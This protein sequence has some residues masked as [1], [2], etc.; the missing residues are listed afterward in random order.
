M[1]YLLTIISSSLLNDRD[2]LSKSRQKLHANCFATEKSFQFYPAKRQSLANVILKPLSSKHVFPIVQTLQHRLINNA[3]I[4]M[5]LVIS[6]RAQFFFE[7]SFNTLFISPRVARVRVC[8]LPLLS[9][10][11]WTLQRTFQQFMLLPKNDVHLQV[12]RPLISCMSQKCKSLPWDISQCKHFHNLSVSE[13]PAFWN[14][15]RVDHHLQY[16]K[17]F[18]K[19]LRGTENVFKSEPPSQTLKMNIQWTQNEPFDEHRAC[20][21]HT[22]TFCMLVFNT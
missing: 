5:K 19:A 9:K 1:V 20:Q 17:I 18:T 13:C 15:F 8:A 2:S 14:F 10:L 11:H 16:Y 4:P 6:G 12:F 22:L 7:K 21:A 3:F